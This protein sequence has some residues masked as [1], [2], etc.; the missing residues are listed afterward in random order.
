MTPM[1]GRSMFHVDSGGA[2]FCMACQAVGIVVLS[3]RTDVLHY[4]VFAI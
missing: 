1:I 4:D 3:L 2:A